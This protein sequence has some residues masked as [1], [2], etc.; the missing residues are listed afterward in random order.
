MELAQLMEEL[1]AEVQREA[2]DIQHIELMQANVQRDVESDVQH[3]DKAVS[4]AWS[5]RRKKWILLGIRMHPICHL[6]ILVVCCVFDSCS[7]SNYYSDS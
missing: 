5:A 6:N 2:E 1:M 4:H 7:H 3:L